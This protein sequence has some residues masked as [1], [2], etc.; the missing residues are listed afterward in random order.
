MPHQ[1]TRNENIVHMFGH[2]NCLK[3]K[4]GYTSGIVRLALQ[5]Q[6]SGSG[7]DTQAAEDLLL[8]SKPLTDLISLLV[9]LLPNED[10]EI[11]DVSSK[12]L[13]ILVWLCGGENPGSLSPENVE[14]F[15]HLRTSKEDPKEQKLLLRTLRR[16]VTSNEKHLES[17]KNADSLL[18]A[19]ERMAP[20]RGSLPDSMEAPLALEI[21]QAV[22]R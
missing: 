13:S 22:G 8:L 9:P 5:A 14:I 11:F 4:G 21:L 18:Q 12:C 16:M 17:L 19:L 10:P 1:E 6:K 15:A 20:R 3:E 2:K 7:K